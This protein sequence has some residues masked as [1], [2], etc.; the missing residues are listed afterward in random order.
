MLTCAATYVIVIETLWWW[1]PRLGPRPVRWLGTAVRST[2]KLS[3]LRFSPG[4]RREARPVLNEIYSSKPRWKRLAFSADSQTLAV[5]GHEGR[6]PLRVDLSRSSWGAEL[7]DRRVAAISD[8]GKLAELSTL[9]A[10]VPYPIDHHTGPGNQYLVE[11]AISGRTGVEMAAQLPVSQLV[12]TVTGA[13]SQLHNATATMITFDDGQL[14]RWVEIPLRRL[15]T[16]VRASATEIDTIGEILH[17]GLRGRQVEAARLHGNLTLYVT[18]FDQHGRLTGLLDWEWSEVGP[19]FLDQGSLALH[20]L[21]VETRTDIGHAV[22]D[23]LADPDSFTDH[24]A[25]SMSSLA[26]IDPRVLVLAAWLHLLTPAVRAAETTPAGRFWMARNVRPV[27]TR[28][29]RL[30]A[31]PA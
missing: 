2:R 6:P 22:G 21:A 30:V 23:A 9:R 7:L 12:D 24:R 26:G 20:A 16:A 27:L 28:L 25:L 1:A 15:S 29:P 19:V 10:L 11:S 18:L 14:E 3:R 4:L 13:V 5:S 17:D 8:L 31:Q